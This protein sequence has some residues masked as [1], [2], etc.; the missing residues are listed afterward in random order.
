LGQ[1]ASDFADEIDLIA[2]WQTGETLLIT[3]MLMSQKLI[4]L[5]EVM[6]LD[7]VKKNY[8][9]KSTR[10]EADRYLPTGIGC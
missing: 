3:A 10:Q 2:D 8:G 4:G 9:I 1:T 5:P 6:I 7:C